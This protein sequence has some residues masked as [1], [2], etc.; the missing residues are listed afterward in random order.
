VSVFLG[1][2]GLWQIVL[3]GLF[4]GVLLSFTPCVLPMVPI[5][6]SLIAGSTQTRAGARVRGSAGHAGNLRLAL[7]YVFGTSLVYTAL[8]VAAGLA[9]ASLA[10]WLQTPWVLALFAALLGVLA[11]AMFG[12]FQFQA[13]LALQTAVQAR[14]ARI[15]GG[16]ASG[17]FLMG[18]LSALIVGPCVAAPLA[19]VLLFISA[20]GDVWQGGLAL[21]ALAWGQGVLLLVLGASSGAWLP[22]AGAWMERVQHGFGV[23]LLATAWWML[24]PVLP[25]AVLMLGWVVLAFWAALILGALRPLATDAGAGRLLARALGTVLAAWGFILLVGLATGGRDALRPLEK[26]AQPSVVR[27]TV[28]GAATPTFTRVDSVADLN[29]ALAR[30]HQPVV[31]DFYAD[32]C[33][34]CKEMERF[35]FS[36]PE[37]AER[38]AQFTLLQVD[39]TR[40]TADDRALRASLYR[41]YATLAS[42]QGDDAALDNSP[43]IE[44]LLALRAEEA[45]LIGHAHYAELRLQTRMAQSTDQVQGMLRDLAAR[46]RLHAEQDLAALRDF[47]AQ[48]LGIDDL[49]PWDFAWVAEKLRQSRYDYSEDAVRQ[50]FPLPQVLQG[51][52]QVVQT[53]FGVTL[54]AEDHPV[55]HAHAQVLRVQGE[56][57]QTLGYLYLDLHARAGKQSGAW[58]DSERTRQRLAGELLVPVVMLTC[59]F[60]APQDGRAALLTHDEVITLFHESGHA[61]HALL[62]TQ[63]EAAL[64]PFA[65][66]EWDAIELPSQFMENFC[67]DWDVVQSLSRHVDTGERLPRALFDKMLAARLFQGGMRL[68]RQ[69]EFALFDMAIHA[70]TQGLPVAQVMHTLNAVRAEVAVVTPPTWH[71]F[72]HNF[73]HIFAG[74]YG[75][76]YYSYLWAEVLSADAFA[77]F[78]E[79]GD[80]GVLNPALGRK[81]RDEILAVGGAR[82]TDASFRAFRGRDVSLEALLR[83]NGM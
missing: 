7:L 66:V 33:I 15:P 79:A 29:R 6:L 38:L 26:L 54:H 59:N 60:P 53:L 45:G 56:Q 39:V 58:V 9:G 40:D 67:W 77:A 12:V 5:L 51:L 57:G 68:L 17:A 1:S 63:D 73:S 13:P 70:Q 46:A 76:G 24:M 78:E 27:N 21:F 28:D 50:Y 14:L 22:K 32:W 61:L 35:T 47:A 75:A 69:I 44:E 18:M 10:A 23:L 8:G 62:S 41:A 81:F 19:G 16:H 25:A 43:L 72:P 48:D 34:A 20:T 3:A 11:L 71:R 2:A 49:Q 74:G 30:A 31:L 52:F 42:D 37:V 64:S 65:S 80:S 82:P 55:W 36:E 83:H 4:L